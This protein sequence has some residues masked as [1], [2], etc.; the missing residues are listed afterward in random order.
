[1]RIAQAAVIIALGNVTSRLLGI[2]RELV[3]A[4]LFGATGTTD[5]F[6]AAATVPTMVYDLL[7]GGAITAALIPVLSDY[8][9]DR[10]D[11]LSKVA[12][13]ALNLA[14]LVLVAVVA[15]AL[16]LAPQ[17]VSLLGPGFSPIVRDQA[18][19]MVRIILPAV[20]FLGL[21]GVTTGLLYARRRFVLPAFA[22]AIYN[23]GIIGAAI[24]LSGTFGAASLVI[25]VLTGSLL[26][27]LLQAPALGGFRYRPVLSL[28]HPGVR[29]MAA[30]Y[31]PVMGGLVVSQIG[32]LIDRNLASQ[33]GEGSMAAMRFATTLVQFP[34]GLVAS[35]VAFAVLPT[36][37][38]HAA[39]ALGSGDPSAYKSTLAQGLRMVTVLI[40]P[41]AVGLAIL[42]EPLVQLLFQR[43]AFDAW[44]TE[45]TS[46][47]FLCYSPSI[48]FAAI[49][50]VLIFAFYARKNSL[51]PVLV[52]VL[53]VGVYLAVALTLM[54]SLGMPGLVLANS[55][56][57]IVHAL[58]LMSLLWRALGG[59]R[60][61]GLGPALWKTAAASAI[62]GI[63][64][65][66]AAP[67]ADAWLPGGG[68][69][70]LALRLG[71]LAAL[72]G[73]VYAVCALALGIS[74]LAWLWNLVRSRLGR[75]EK[76]AS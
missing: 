25:G 62:M 65:L 37:S 11:D 50:Q 39:A 31:L 47:A 49:D 22:A 43:G 76:P 41:A 7:I 63:A 30:L 1:M 44:A 6:V 38:R 3:I 58:V 18:I 32:V 5:A 69:A 10:P 70:V 2:V 35:A 34:L 15:V 53:G 14:A 73:G 21:S 60:G 57:W 40:V 17:L 23:L 9:D 59:M 27:I 4:N 64:V 20:V 46:L 12:S 72:G 75:A 8:A 54:P 42:R 33:T 13:T 56:Q 52:G 67:L 61:H 55:A 66:V 36:L 28:S 45:R 68:V 48:P 16:P 19:D 74:D 26:Q 71:L 24:L 29:R 51:T